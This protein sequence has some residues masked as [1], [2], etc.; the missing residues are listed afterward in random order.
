[1]EVLIKITDFKV[2]DLIKR[3]SSND[4]YV[5]ESSGFRCRLYDDLIHLKYENICAHDWE[6]YTKPK[7]KKKVKETWY[8]VAY[9]YTDR[10]NPCISSDLYKSLESFYRDYQLKREDF[11]FQPK[12]ILPMEVEVEVDETES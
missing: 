12:L 5:I 10:S 6:L 9:Q 4:V 7:P 3:K 1:M 11:K 2:G 8:Q